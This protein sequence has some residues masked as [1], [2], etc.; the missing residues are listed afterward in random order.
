MAIAQYRDTLGYTRIRRRAYKPQL[1]HFQVGDYMYLQHKAPKTLDIR[2][3]RTILSVKEILP[4]MVLLWEG[5]D[6]EECK[7]NTKNCALC[8]FPIE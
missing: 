1:R 6:G 5:K 2:A 7:S 3:D 4:N 8:H